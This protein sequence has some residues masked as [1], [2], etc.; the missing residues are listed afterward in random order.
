MLRRS[1]LET[2]L[3]DRT[4]GDVVKLSP[5]LSSS[6]GEITTPAHVQCQL[7]LFAGVDPNLFQNTKQQYGDQRCH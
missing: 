1:C 6:F 7:V 5:L 2:A 3:A 4:C